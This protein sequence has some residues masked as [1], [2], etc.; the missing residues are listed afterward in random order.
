MNNTKKKYY[1]EWIYSFD[2]KDLYQEVAEL[3]DAE[4]DRIVSFLEKMEEAG[5]IGPSQSGCDFVF[6]YR[7]PEMQTFDSLQAAWANGS[8]IDCGKSEGI[9]L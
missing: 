7:E 2:D 3:T 1:V 6:P 9:E 5:Y 4:R 8:I